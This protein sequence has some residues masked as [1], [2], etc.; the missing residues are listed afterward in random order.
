MRFF[1]SG[2]AF[3]VLFERERAGLMKGESLRRGI[4]NIYMG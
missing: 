2:L 4:V 3:L 1:Y